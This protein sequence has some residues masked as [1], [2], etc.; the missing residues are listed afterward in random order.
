MVTYSSQLQNIDY[1]YVLVTRQQQKDVFRTYR[2]RTIQLIHKEWKKVWLVSRALP[3]RACNSNMGKQRRERT[4]YHQTSKTQKKPPLNATIEDME[5][6]PILLQP[7]DNL[8]AGI[9]IDIDKPKRIDMDTLSVRSSK[10]QIERLPKKDKLQLRRQ[11]LL[12]KLNSTRKLR[13]K[14]STKAPQQELSAL[15]FE[16]KKGRRN[17]EMKPKKGTEKEVKR[18]RNF[19]KNANVFKSLIYRKDLKD[20][21]QKKI[22]GHMDGMVERAKKQR[23]KHT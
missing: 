20:D 1:A 12:E 11:A 13:N 22:A 23:M 4:K 6:Q 9:D 2:E 16:V 7:S 5:T 14:K 10:S 15:D 3:R 19:L 21:L 18:K 8:F 17:N